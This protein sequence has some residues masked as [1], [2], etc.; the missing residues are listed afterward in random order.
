[1]AKSSR[2]STNRARE[3]AP[4]ST[5]TAPGAAAP[6]PHIPSQPSE[7]THRLLRGYAFDPSLATQLETALVS[8]ITYKVPW[9][10]LA[11][12][13]IGKYVEVVDF[14][15]AS[16]CFYAPVNLDDPRVLSQNGLAPSEGNPQFHQQMV[17]AVAMTTIDRFE[18]A[19]GRKA[20]WTDRYRR[21]AKTD[22]HAPS[23]NRFVQRLRIYPHALRMANAYYS[24]NKGSLLFGYFPATEDRTSGQFPGGVVFSC[25]SH[26]VIA[27]ETT[28][29]LLDGFNQ[30]YMEATNQDMLAFHEALA[31]IVALMQHFTFPEVLAHQIAKTRGDLASENLLGQLA[32]Q[33][34][35]AR[36]THGALR[37]AIGKYDPVQKKWIPHV[38][39]PTELDHTAEVHG[40]GAILVAAVF[41]A[42][43]SIYQSRTRD[44]VRL[45]SGGTGV[46]QQ[47]ELHPDLVGR[48]AREAS[49]AA[50]HVLNIC[51][52][53]LDYCPPVDLTFGEY[54]RALI[55]ADMDLMPEDQHRYR[56]AFIEA[57]RRRGIYPRDVRTLSEDSLRW[58][59]PEEDPTLGPGKMKNMLKAFITDTN[60]RGKIDEM[61]HLRE[62]VDIPPEE[63][64]RRE[65][66]LRAQLHESIAS[67][68]SK[69]KILERVTGLALT[70]YSVPEG[71][72]VRRDGL[73]AFSV[74]AIR[75][76]RRQKEDGRV[77]NQAFVTILQKETVEHEGRAHTI[78]C[79]S[80][81]VLD[82]SEPRVTYVIAKGLQDQARFM[83]TVTFNESQASSASLAATYFGH[84]NEPFAALHRVGA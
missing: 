84:F 19:L 71:V 5:A 54:L 23:E 68:V 57:F 38:P 32:T 17:Y 12:G 81:L 77:L 28:H 43:L 9:E 34:G 74:H 11:P 26:D 35:H 48:L 8:E 72:S 58:A 61:R 25:L 31:D 36:G 13:P 55:T 46:L 21:A 39:D 56:V 41:D 59:Q 49:K 52:R 45:A 65:S 63:I 51:I 22:G 53:A 3:A 70:D 18:R 7:P 76:A 14:D 73:P 1:M 10:P 50:G 4:P 75:E 33:F 64:W 60:L 20:L 82:L 79:G 37:D 40:R 78:R 69:A 42:F 47:G 83:R 80:T 15:P 66:V 44:L 67:A 30:Y 2:A 27:H 24:R 62:R 16:G 29:A 6:P